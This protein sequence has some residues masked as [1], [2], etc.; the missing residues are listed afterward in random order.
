MASRRRLLYLVAFLAGSLVVLVLAAWLALQTSWGMNYVRRIAERQASSA[1]GAQVAIG[2]LRGSLFYGATIDRLAITD[3]GEELA[4]AALVS[5]RYDLFD[6]VRGTFAL[7]EIVVDGPVIHAKAL[8]LLGREEPEDP[9]PTDRAFS[10]ERI[11]IKN[12]QVVFGPEPSEAGGFEIPD[13][14]R[15]V[16]ADLSVQIEPEAT[17][18]AVD[19]LSFVGEAPDVSLRSLSGVVA[20]EGNDLV[21]EDIFVQLAESSMKLNGTI[22]NFRNLGGANGAQVEGTHR[23]ADTAVGRR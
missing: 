1:L 13:V 10:I 14:L 15:D 8:D 9:Q 16:Q 6:L 22:A 19:H 12:G 17:R 23:S 2:A 20:I 7:D 21:L 5:A 3:D 11:V 18:V 4:S